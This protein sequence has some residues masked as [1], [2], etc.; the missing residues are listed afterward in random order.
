[1]YYVAILCPPGID[2]E[3]L[4]FKNFMKDRFG[5]TA[6]LKSPAH[7]TMVTP[8]WF[9]ETREDELQQTL[10]S[11]ASDL[12]DLQIQLNGFSHFNKRVLFVN[13]EDNPGIEEIRNQAE[14]HF[15]G[16]LGDAI[17]KDD[18]PFHPHVTIAT[19]DMKPGDF[20]EAWEHFSR[21]EFMTSFQTGTINLLKLDPDRWNVI[22]EKKWKA[23]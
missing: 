14:R 15:I 12:N 3:I 16:S 6:A 22:G 19:R 9:E 23:P 7:I 8:F 21:K 4:G 5:C 13:I 1:M 11:F 17:R 2:K 20:T 18:R 10:Q